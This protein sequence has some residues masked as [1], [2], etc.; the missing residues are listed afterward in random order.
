MAERQVRM[1]ALSATMEDAE[2]LSWLV[3]V[4][5]SVRSGQPLAEVST[6]KVYMEL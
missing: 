5:D 1:P 6:D 2:L 3:A 4:G